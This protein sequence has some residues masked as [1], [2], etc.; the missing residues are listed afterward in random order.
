MSLSKPVCEYEGCTNTAEVR[1]TFAKIDQEATD[2][3]PEAGTLVR[4]G[5]AQDL[6]RAH[7]EQ[8]YGE[9]PP[10]WSC[11]FIPYTRNGTLASDE[12]SPASEFF[13]E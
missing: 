11:T 1:A 10:D 12:A 2:A 5:R 6:C 8:A 13:G 4:E 9:N 3:A 7:F